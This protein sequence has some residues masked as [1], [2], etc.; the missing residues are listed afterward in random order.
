MVEINQGRSLRFPKSDRFI[1]EDAPCSF[2]EALL[3]EKSD[4]TTKEPQS[5]LFKFPYLEH[6]ILEWLAK[7]VVGRFKQSVDFDRLKAKIADL[8]LQFLVALVG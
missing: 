3:G 1:K 8:R 2:K 5:R 6:A 7:S 4:D